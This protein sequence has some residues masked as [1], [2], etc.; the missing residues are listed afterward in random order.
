MNNE[1][2]EQWSVGVG[3][4]PTEGE[5]FPDAPSPKWNDIPE[6]SEPKVVKLST[7]L[8]QICGVGAWVIIGILAAA[9]IA[10]ILNRYF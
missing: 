9:A 1:S 7:I 3:E 8:G 5:S 4:S 2:V 10:G 6:W